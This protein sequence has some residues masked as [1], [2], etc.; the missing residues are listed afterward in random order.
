MTEQEVSTHSTP[1][2]LDE[3]MRKACKL[4]REKS[5]SFEV[6]S[7]QCAL[8]VA[9]WLCRNNHS[10]DE[11]LA[12]LLWLFPQSE[13]LRLAPGYLL[14]AIEALPS[15]WKDILRVLNKAQTLRF[16]GAFLAA[17]PAVSKTIAAAY[18]LNLNEH[19]CRKIYEAPD[20][21]TQHISTKTFL[22]N[23]LSLAKELARSAAD[24]TADKLVE[25]VEASIRDAALVSEL[26]PRSTW[27]WEIEAK[28]E[29]TDD[30]AGQSIKLLNR[31]LRRFWLTT[32]ICEESGTRVGSVLL[33]R[34]ETGNDEHNSALDRL[35]TSLAIRFSGLFE[36]RKKRFSEKHQTVC[37]DRT[38][39][40][41]WHMGLGYS[42]RYK[43][44]LGSR[45]ADPLSVFFKKHMAGSFEEELNQLKRMTNTE[46]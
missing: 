9:G 30:R 27:I 28:L 12:A 3:S 24:T 25:S 41:S 35:M 16:D 34:A 1:A 31:L 43:A 32:A 42:G 45:E 13:R 44:L 18:L 33:V 14:P 23:F 36:I 4:L 40:S 37:F 17:A 2:A 6:I 10:Q 15:L 8:E 38:G 11:Q 7:S 29:P 19:G 26:L 21:L 22:E 5:M 39:I 20:R 46:S